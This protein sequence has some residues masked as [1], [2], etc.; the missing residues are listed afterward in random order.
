MLALRETSGRIAPDEKHDIADF[1]L[2][3]FGHAHPSM[4]T[5]QQDKDIALRIA[6]GGSGDAQKVPVLA[7]L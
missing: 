5:E 1:D 7:R 4:D 3:D 6:A 2:G